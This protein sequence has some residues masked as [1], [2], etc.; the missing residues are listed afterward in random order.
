M[1]HV[2]SHDELWNSI[3]LTEDGGQFLSY[4]WRLRAFVR[5]LSF[6]LL[7]SNMEMER[8]KQGNR[9]TDSTSIQGKVREI[10]RG[11][12]GIKSVQPA[13]SEAQRP[14]QFL[15]LEQLALGEASK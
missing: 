8:A 3:L 15:A 10:T 1:L 2:A 7:H 6:L 4:D 5:H 14:F 9:E 13:R 12:M 11:N